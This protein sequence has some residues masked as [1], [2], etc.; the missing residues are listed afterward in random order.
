L[1]LLTPAAQPPDR[2]RGVPHLGR[3]ARGA[4]LV[5]GL[6]GRDG[7]AARLRPL[8]TGARGPGL[9]DL[10]AASAPASAGRSRPDDRPD[11][12]HQL[13]RG[14]LDVSARVRPSA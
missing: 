11:P 10:D 14:P 2:P 1:L 13:L 8:C 9:L 5:A 12:G 4:P 7:V 3:P 6:A